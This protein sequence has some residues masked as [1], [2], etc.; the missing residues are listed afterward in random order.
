[1]L[2]ASI[3]SPTIA[4]LDRRNPPGRDNLLRGEILRIQKDAGGHNTDRGY[5]RKSEEVQAIRVV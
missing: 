2:A 5:H 4:F 3:S 1:M